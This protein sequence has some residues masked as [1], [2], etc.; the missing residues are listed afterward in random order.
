MTPKTWNANSLVLPNGHIQTDFRGKWVNFYEDNI[1]KPIDSSLKE[2]GNNWVFRNGPF[3][4][5]LPKLSNGV[6]E[7]VSTNK[8][9][10]FSKT[11]ITDADFSVRFTPIGV[12]IVDGIINPNK[13][14][15]LVFVNAYPFG[16]LIYNIERSRA[17]RLQKLVRFNSEPAGNQ[18]I[19]IQFNIT[20]D[21]DDIYT[22]D[23]VLSKKDQDISDGL[24]QEIS[25]E[26]KKKDNN[27]IEIMRKLFE[28]KGKTKKKWDGKNKTITT[29]ICFHPENLSN[30]RGVGFK[31]FKVW[32]SS[33]KSEQINVRFERQLNGSIILTKI[34]PRKFLQEATYPVY[35]DTTSTFYPDPD[36]EVTSVDGNVTRDASGSSWSSLRD[37]VGTTADDVENSTIVVRAVVNADPTLFNLLARG[38]FLFD[39]ST[40]SDNDTI[41]EATLSIYGS[42]KTNT[43][44][45]DMD[46][47][48]Y[49]S[50]PASN[51]ALVAA[52]Y[53]IA[54]FGSTAFSSTISYTNWALS[55][56]NAFVLNGNGL[57]NISKTGVSKFGARNV[58]YDVSNSAPSTVV[59]G[60]NNLAC[61]MSEH[62]NDPKLVVTSSPP[63]KPASFLMIG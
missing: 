58:N 59:A 56:Y 11:K 45:I 38:V 5:S 2:E 33:G 15:E 37:G 19:E 10:I 29:P 16:D 27:L 47:N 30:N 26:L 39:T 40:I 20:H 24:Q 1:W 28:I 6:A 3:T 62:V 4:A 22:H 52:D 25:A 12:S 51:T 49:S 31:Q 32:D 34:V 14:T 17:P 8:W 23:I 60:Q 57:S 18:N 9:D 54:N 21:K 48:I 50:S 36:V 53:N 46:I 55:A 61:Q 44:S 13:S 63:T 7:F 42:N 35:T 43:S 41:T